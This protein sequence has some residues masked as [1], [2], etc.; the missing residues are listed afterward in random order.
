MRALRV[1][2]RCLV[3]LACAALLNVPA[4]AGTL[5]T[6][7]AGTFIVPMQAIFKQTQGDV[8]LAHGMLYRLL[9]RDGVVVYRAIDRD[10]AGV[11]VEDFTVK[12]AAGKVVE[13]YLGNSAPAGST[14]SY[15]GGAW[16]IAPQYQADLDA[17]LLDPTWAPVQIHRALVPFTAPVVTVPQV[18]SRPITLLVS[19]DDVE[20]ARA[21]AVMEWFLTPE[22]LATS[23]GTVTPGEIVSGALDGPDAPAILLVPY[24]L[25]LLEVSTATADEVLSR[26]H[27][28]LRAG[29]TLIAQDDAV[30]FLENQATGRFLTTGGIG[31]N[32]VVHGD[33]S[34]NLV[35]ASA[36][37]LALAPGHPVAQI[38]DQ[39]EYGTY[40]AENRA[41]VPAT[42][43][44]VRNFSPYQGDGATLS[45]YGDP[46]AGGAYLPTV[47]RL[48]SWDADG[49][50][51]RW[52]LAVVGQS[53]GVWGNGSVFYLGGRLVP[54]AA[55]QESGGKD[56]QIS[57]AFRRVFLNGL[58]LTSAAAP[59]E[60][61]AHAGVTVDRDFIEFQGST[62][63]AHGRG[64]LQA[65]DATADPATLLWD[66]ADHVPA[67]G[68]RRI[69]T[70]DNAALA[71]VVPGNGFVGSLLGL[72]EIER[73]RGRFL[74]QTGAY[75]N[76]ANRLGAIAH[77]TAVAVGPSLRVEGA[78]AR[79][80]NVYVGTLDGLLE[81]VDADPASGQPAGTGT[82]MWAV[83]P[84]CQIDRLAAHGLDADLGVDGS[85]TAADLWVDHNGVQAFRTVLTVPMGASSPHILALDISDRENP[86]V[87][88]E[89]TVSGDVD[90]GFAAKTAM[91][92][93]ATDDGQGNLVR[94]A[95]VWVSTS[96][97]RQ[98]GD[99][100][101][102]SLYC[103]RAEDG[104]TVWEFHQPYT[105]GV[106][107]VPP[108]VVAVD[109]DGDG[110]I[111]TL[112][113]GDNEGRLWAVDARTGKSLFEDA[114]NPTPVYPTGGSDPDRPIGASPAVVAEGGQTIVLFG[115]GGYDWAPA[116]TVEQHF[117]GLLVPPQGAA[118]ELFDI[119]LDP[120]DR[121]YASPVVDRHAH[122]LFLGKSHGRAGSG[123]TL[124]DADATATVE[125][126]DISDALTG[127]P[128]L[129][130]KAGSDVVLS[131]AL[132]GGLQLQGGVLFGANAGG[133]QFHVGDVGG[134]AASSRPEPL[135]RLYW[136]VV[137]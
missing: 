6:F 101:G 23:F 66:A 131:Q 128:G 50:G 56:P 107:D 102:L 132:S 51:Y 38:G 133:E 71:E 129:P 57:T 75:Q 96:K 9:Q 67:D 120:G 74:D 134:G 42:D 106:N 10:K 69:F 105:S 61:V 103:L 53:E 16:L 123:P 119:A 127:N 121:V 94:A 62:S 110:F 82:E 80:R 72:Q 26:I 5:K 27:V 49:S 14:V 70:H 64:H 92:H 46:Q 54:D 79:G 8:L 60:Q 45:G 115:T 125:T 40:C 83:V 24:A 111:E 98:L 122:Y 36:L 65:F 86:E 1:A 91:G 108:P 124:P 32:G 76:L 55:A 35:P 104:V 7:P 52:D 43:G 15:R 30:A 126:Y 90:M 58:F 19:G 31:V 68:S 84:R 81:A 93:I 136:L 44:L 95:V 4:A 99:G 34:N 29:N 28:W 137:P 77:S 114:G 33:G 20:A 135:T 11:E 116:E 118:V 109:P 117:V 41:C 21:R 100:G 17:V 88:W 87:L 78:E 48:H 47:R 113:A 97:Y 12:A 73:L 63:A 89:K 18:S 22:G 59:V 112:F 13:N 39:G 130:A 85:P 37:Q 2:H 25:P 3:V